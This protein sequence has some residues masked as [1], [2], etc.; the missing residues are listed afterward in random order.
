VIYA[1]VEK[2][3]QESGISPED[4]VIVPN[5]PGYYVRTGRSAIRLPL[6]DESTVLD[7]AKR[8]G[9]AYLI[10]EQSNSYVGLQDLYDHPR[11]NPAFVY[12]GE[13]EGSHLY[14]IEGID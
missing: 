3:L 11:G 6:G 1:S 5:P 2:K 8:F 12:L 9:A 7:V 4:I 10:L 13:V 14:R